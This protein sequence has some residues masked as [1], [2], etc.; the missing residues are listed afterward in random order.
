MFG[1]QK[2]YLSVWSLCNYQLRVSTTC[3]HSGSSHTISTYLRHGHVSVLDWPPISLI[4]CRLE[5][6]VS[7]MFVSNFTFQY[8]AILIYEY[9]CDLVVDTII[10][11]SVFLLDWTPIS[12]KFFRFE[13]TLVTSGNVFSTA[14]YDGHCGMS[15]RVT[16]KLVWAHGFPRI[17]LFSAWSLFCHL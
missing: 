8:L 10:D 4:C 5:S 15:L 16:S 12:P 3:Y 17:L 11:L 7:K 1:R 14:T 2:K 9:W 13:S 6:V